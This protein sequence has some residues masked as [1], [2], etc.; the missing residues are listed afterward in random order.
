MH[1]LGVFLN[2]SL[3]LDAQI[4]VVARSALAQLKLVHKLCLL[5]EKCDLD[6]VTHALV[7]SQLD[8]RNV[9]YV[10]RLMES[11]RKRL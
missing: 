9:I 11:V 6:T 1:I 10:G 7:T 4:F 8:Y 3:S 2:S 5:L